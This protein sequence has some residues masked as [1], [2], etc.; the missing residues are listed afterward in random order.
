VNKLSFSEESF[1]SSWELDV[2]FVEVGVGGGS[3]L[4]AC[5]LISEKN[6]GEPVWSVLVKW[7]ENS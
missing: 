4:Q 2:V 3:F 6:G 1:L 5:A 7:G